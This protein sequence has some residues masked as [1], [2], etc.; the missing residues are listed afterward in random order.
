MKMQYETSRSQKDKAGSGPMHIMYVGVL[1]TVMLLQP[2]TQ[3][4]GPRDVICTPSRLVR[5]TVCW[6]ARFAS[7]S[8]EK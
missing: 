7:A 2:Q 1:G 8:N 6:L 3:S 4:D 5:G